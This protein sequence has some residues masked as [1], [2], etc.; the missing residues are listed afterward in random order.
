MNGNEVMSSND[1][2]TDGE[3][4]G[5]PLK[6][7]EAEPLGEVA[8]PLSEVAEPLGE[9]AQPVENMMSGRV[10]RVFD[11]LLTRPLGPGLYLVATPIGNLTDISLRALATL[12]RARFVAAEDTRHSAKL[13][14]HYGIKSEM[15]SY[16]DHNGQVMGPKIVKMI[17]QGA[18]VALISDAGTP[19]ISDPGFKLA[20]LVRASGFSV[21]VVP[22]ASAVMAGLS[23]SGL[24]TDRFLFEGFLPPK[25]TARRKRLEALADIPSSLVFF[26]TVKRIDAVIQEM[27]ALLGDRPAALLREL[28]KLHEEVIEGRLSELSSLLSSRSLKGELV[29]VVGPPEAVEVTE[30]M[31]TA[32]LKEA[33]A[34]GL[35]ARDSVKQV[36]AQY[37]LPK[38]R[39][40]ERSIALKH[41]QE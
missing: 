30:E 16:H 23:L 19:L 4:E 34:K 10:Q 13:L 9:V 33:M 24:P 6:N 28:T 21:E 39:V 20:K 5:A 15:I 22:G 25:E 31:I 8:Q 18:S 26:E 32:A 1:T 35:S 11:D 29:L 36:A 7:D 14:H 41:E 12:A 2:S 40:Y 3:G 17:K 27:T 37:D 38:G